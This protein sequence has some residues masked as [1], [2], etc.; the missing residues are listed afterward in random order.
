MKCELFCKPFSKTR[1]KLA[2]LCIWEYWKT[3]KTHK[4][5]CVLS[6]FHEKI[7][8]FWTDPRISDLDL[9]NWEFKKKNYRIILLL[10]RLNLAIAVCP[11]NG[12]PLC[13]FWVKC[14][15]TMPELVIIYKIN[16]PFQMPFLRKVNPNSEILLQFFS[17]KPFP[18]RP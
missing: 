12:F 14:N 7:C 4:N 18:F 5:T 1:K 6:F 16:Q 9:C 8:F 15:G 3:P 10:K 11:F 13:N 17:V 2:P